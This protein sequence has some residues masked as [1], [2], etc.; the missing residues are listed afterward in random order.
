MG[1]NIPPLTPL[2]AGPG[3]TDRERGGVGIVGVWGWAGGQA[4]YSRVIGVPEAGI[5]PDTKEQFK[6]QLSGR[7]GGGRLP[8]GPQ[9][10][11]SWD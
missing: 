11:P 7:R 10:T 5:R 2:G 9:G 6:H 8:G 1:H 3:E 4:D